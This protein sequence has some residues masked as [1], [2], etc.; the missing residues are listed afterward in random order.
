MGTFGADLRFAV[1]MLLKNR[2]FTA[3]AVVTLALGIGAN[4]AI[5]T[6]VDAVLLKPLPY[7]EPDRMVRLSR[8]FADGRGDSNSIPKFMVWRANNHVFS[9]MALYDFNGP[10]MTLGESDPPRQVRGMHVSREYFQVFGAAPA[11]G[12]SFS[13]AEDLPGGWPI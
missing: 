6:V 12:R 9:S 8:Q 2:W 1:R 5:F 7:P 4:T 10:V 3:V 11:L 13:A